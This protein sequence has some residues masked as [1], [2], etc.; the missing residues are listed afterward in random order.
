M[1]NV[2]QRPTHET[3]R[4][5]DMRLFAKVAEVRSFSAAARALRIPKQTVSRRIAEL[6]RALDVQLVHRTTRRVHLTDVGEAYA[7]RCAEVARLADE[8]NR[9]ITDSHATPRGTLRVT[10]DPLFGDAFLSELVL[11]YAALHSEVSVDV[12]L[13][14]R[15]VDLVQEGFDVAFR[16]GGV[17]DPSLTGIELGPAR[18]RYCASPG[19]VSRRGAPETP[20][21]LDGHECVVV[22]DEAAAPRWPFEGPDGQLRLV[23]VRG[24]LTLTSFAM[25]HAAARAGLGIALFPEFACAEDLRSGALVTVLPAHVVRVGSVWL[26]HPRARALTARVRAFVELAVARLRADPPW[27]S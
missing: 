16:I 8:A 15:R 18:V 21:D 27:V 6:E 24:R 14:R 4:L 9:A 10:A 26:V 19:Y 13:T 22:G 17:D 7:Q 12:V 5:E 3:V 1:K 11:E 23:P 2:T 20:E 25:A